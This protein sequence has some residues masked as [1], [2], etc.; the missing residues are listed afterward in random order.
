MLLW[1]ALGCAAQKKVDAPHAAADERVAAERELLVWKVHKPGVSPSYLMGTCH[2][3]VPLAR[4]LPPPHDGALDGSRVVYTEIGDEPIDIMAL[5][6]LIP[7][8]D[9]SLRDEIGQVAFDE[10]SR[11][12]RE[13]MPASMLDVLPTW[14]AFSML[15]LE[16]LGRRFTALNE[17]G[18]VLLDRA[19]VLRAGD[20]GIEVRA[21]ETIDSQIAL[22][23]RF[24]S[25]FEQA[26]DSSSDV[27]SRSK[28]QM[29]NVVELCS[30]FEVAN[31][32]ASLAEH[33]PTGFVDALLGE[34]NRTWMV[35]LRP[36]L[37]RGGVFVAVG[38][39]HML[40]TDGLIAGMEADGF[41]VER[42]V[43]RSTPPVA[44]TYV[45][46]PTT[47]PPGPAD[48]E[49]AGH[50]ARVM[51]ADT[52]PSLC[53]ADGLL[54]TCFGLDET[55]CANEMDRAAEMCV[56]Q[57]G[58]RLP[59]PGVQ[60]DPQ[61]GTEIGACMP[62]GIVFRGIVSGEMGDAPMCDMIRTAMQEATNALMGGM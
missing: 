49:L 42:L 53:A 52:Q 30:T 11:S 37:E 20:R 28:E 62:A 9:T 31:V 5:F 56:A 21:L 24:E 39:A 23:S 33:D 27:A 50:W 45:P 48:P 19:V 61:M 54:R 34:R 59:P 15:D 22:F 38:A 43:G 40:G 12:M 14:I 60:L 35:A 8:R 55:S 1:W 7:V 25:V 17:P 4:W 46:P 10:V 16:E 6:E 44:A 3:Q 58:D 18:H 26:L 29:N 32:E 36:E 41:T 47:T 51:S 13:V 57:Q 2:L